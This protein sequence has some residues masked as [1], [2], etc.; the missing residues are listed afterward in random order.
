MELHREFQGKWAQ[1][2]HYLPGRTPNSIRQ[3]WHGAL[4]GGDIQRLQH[5]LVDGKVPSAFPNGI[6]PLPGAPAA[7]AASS[8]NSS[9]CAKRG[10]EE[11]PGGS[12]AKKGK[13]TGAA[14][15][16]GAG[17]AAAAATGG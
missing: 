10:R 12:A 9:S 8:S 16:K 7:G 14:S 17:A 5:L 11:D 6:P 3:H 15:K 2:A 13:G 4:R 1:I